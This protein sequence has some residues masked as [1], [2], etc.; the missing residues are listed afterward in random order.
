[1]KYIYHIIDHIKVY[2]EAIRLKLNLN[3]FH[4]KVRTAQP[5]LLLKDVWCIQPVRWEDRVVNQTV[6]KSETEGVL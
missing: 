4:V 3:E 2:A 6:G 1:M 5:S